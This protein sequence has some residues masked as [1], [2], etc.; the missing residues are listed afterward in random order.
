MGSKPLLVPWARGSCFGWQS[1]GASGFGHVFQG[2]EWSGDFVRGWT[3]LDDSL[4]N[5]L[6]KDELKRL[7]DLLNG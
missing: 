7:K 4:W 2:R 5:G 6:S 1:C 3:V